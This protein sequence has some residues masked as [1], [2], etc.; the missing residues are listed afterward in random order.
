MIKYKIIFIFLLNS[1]FCFSQ[2]KVIEQ[3]STNVSL[4]GKI[5]HTLADQTSGLSRKLPIVDPLTSLGNL[6]LNQYK[7]LRKEA[8][9]IFKT[10]GI[11]NM[12]FLKG[13]EFSA[14][15]LFFED[16]DKYLLTF[17][18]SNYNYQ[19]ESIW[20]SKQT[21]EELY[22]LIVTELEKKTK[23][24]NIEVVLD[25]NVVLLISINRKKV[26]FNLWDGYNFVQ[27]YW[28]R[29]FKINKLFGN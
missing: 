20:L 24:K 7:E 4:V 5:S 9:D 15:L 22:Q 18:N 2:I 26:S 23:Y 13:E 12:S 28:Y 6:D 16:K 21:K 29:L 25:D 8:N 14:T 17:R 19:N 27:S 11:R 10:V 1:I 3:K